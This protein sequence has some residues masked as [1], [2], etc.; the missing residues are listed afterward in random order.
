MFGY[1]Y[2]QVASNLNVDVSTVWRVVKLS[3]EKYVSLMAFMSS[4]GV[5]DS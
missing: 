1:K 3:Q 5:L 4:S 2:G